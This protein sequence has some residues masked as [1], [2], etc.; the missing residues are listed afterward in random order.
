MSTDQRF[1]NITMG[2]HYCCFR[3]WPTL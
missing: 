1:V 3:L 2:D